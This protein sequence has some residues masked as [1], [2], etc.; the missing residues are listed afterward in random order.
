MRVRY[1]LSS[2]VI[3]LTVI[4]FLLASSTLTRAYVSEGKTGNLNEQYGRI[5]LSFVRNQGQTDS[6]VRFY[7]SSG[8]HETFFTD[9]G[10]VLAITPPDE[11]LLQEPSAFLEREQKQPPENAHL[12]KLTPVGMMRSVQI[13]AEEALPGK[14]NYFIGDDPEKW[15]ADVPTFRSVV[16]REA[17]PGVDFKFY[18]NNQH[19]EYD[20]IV[21]P[22]GDPSQVRLQYTGVQR[23]E[24]T[25]KGDLALQVTTDLALTQRA[26]VVYQ[27]ID[28]KRVELAGK[29]SVKS[30]GHE[31][32]SPSTLSPE[33]E[34]SPEAV[35]SNSSTEHGDAHIVGFEV[36]SYDK[37]YPLVIDPIL[38]YSSF[39]GGTA[40]DYGYAL[41]VD[42]SH[43]VYLTGHTLSLDFPTEEPY[44]GPYKGAHSK[45]FITKLNAAGDALVYST[46]LG[47]SGYDYGY[48]IALDSTGNAY[49][50][51]YTNSTNFP[52]KNAYQKVKGGG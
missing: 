15:R 42:A 11:E 41:A 48:G 27:V 50:A 37:R 6:K 4:I 44:H 3:F 29:F 17:Y 35:R 26:P 13:S 32:I 23:L 7:E 18:G 25:D 20:I 24:I 46:Y 30:F 43:S 22:G 47:G 40:S 45:V 5:P 33:C 31:A 36:A 9:D 12:V 10:V 51:G 21:K 8:G 28:G 39:L 19:L 34:G 52:R 16:Y 38:I 14:V 1:L 2:G 49:V